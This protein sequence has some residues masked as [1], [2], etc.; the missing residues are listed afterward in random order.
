MLTWDKRVFLW[1]S[2]KLS[3]NLWVYGNRIFWSLFLP[4]CYI[5]TSPINILCD[6]AAPKCMIW[7]LSLQT[8]LHLEP[9]LWS[10]PKQRLKHG[11]SLL[12]YHSWTTLNLNFLSL[13]VFSFMLYC[14]KGRRK[15]ICWILIFRLWHLLRY[16]CLSPTW[17]SWNPLPSEGQCPHFRTGRDASTSSAW[18]LSVSLNT[19]HCFRIIYSVVTGVA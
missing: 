3:A 13:K 16:C 19:C 5:L 15:Y 14:E 18:R 10:E 4:F 1:Q 7:Y 17:L 8:C 6:K 11:F 12:L 2:R 9:R